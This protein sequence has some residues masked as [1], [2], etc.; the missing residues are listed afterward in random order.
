L[1][2]AD[3]ERLAQCVAVYLARVSPTPGGDLVARFHLD[4]GA[5]LERVNV[6]ADLSEKGLRESL[7]VMVNYLYDL[8]AVEDNHERFVRGEVVASRAISSMI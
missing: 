3:E 6:G 2:G 4:N 5:R 8:A 1:P 7:G